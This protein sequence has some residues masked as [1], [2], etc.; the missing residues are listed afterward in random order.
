MQSNIDQVY[1]D[2]DLTCET[3]TKDA[4]VNPKAYVNAA[5]T[6]KSGDLAVMFTPDDTHFDI[7][8]EFMKT[9]MQVMVTK[10]IVQRLEDHLKLSEAAKEDNVLV[11]VEL[12]KRLDPFYTDSR[13]LV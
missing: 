4:E 1:K 13:D 2:I 11:G 6:C 9:K 10:P 7:S 3:F 8:M 5:A 12:Q